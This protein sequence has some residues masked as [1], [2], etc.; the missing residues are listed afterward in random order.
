MTQQTSLDEK[1]ILTAAA[2][3]EP[4]E[5]DAGFDF[6]YNAVPFGEYP[7]ATIDAIH[8]QTTAAEDQSS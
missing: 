1:T 5:S 7:E 8:N 6:L 3:K 2:G 4:V